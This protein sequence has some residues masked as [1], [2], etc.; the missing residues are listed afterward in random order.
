MIIAGSIAGSGELATTE[1]T[2]VDAALYFRYGRSD[3]KLRSGRSWD[4]M[5]WLSLVGLAIIGGWALIN[6]FQR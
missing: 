5:V 3:E 4:V 1:K 2:A 6:L